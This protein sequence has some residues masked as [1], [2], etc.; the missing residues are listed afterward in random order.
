MAR[1]EFSGPT[2]RKAFERAGGKC[3]ECDRELRDG[4]PQYDHILEARLGGDG[5]LANCRVLCI[6]CHKAKTKEISQPRITKMKHM[7]D[8]SINAHGPKAKILIRK[9]PHTVSDKIGLPPR[10][11]LYAKDIDHG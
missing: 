4:E 10:R 8:S 11:S 9:K 2:K 7:R 1:L 5:S 3:Q 6:S